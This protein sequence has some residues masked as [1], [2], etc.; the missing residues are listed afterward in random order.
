VDKCFPEKSL[1]DGTLTIS[2]GYALVRKVDR[3]KEAEHQYKMSADDDIHDDFD[4]PAT[5]GN[6]PDGLTKYLKNNL[7]YPEIALKNRIEDK[8]VMRFVVTKQ[9][10]LVYL[11]FEELPQTQDEE[12][13]LEFQ[14]AA[15]YAIK[16]TEG[17]WHPAE[18]D[19]KYV[20]SRVT[21]PVEFSLQK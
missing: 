21:I 13:S 12:I 11:N 3:V 7:A 4:K 18:K 20:M 16:A 9:G 5:L 17:R 14:K 6:S 1:N 10:G 8:V 2:K 15:F 19:G